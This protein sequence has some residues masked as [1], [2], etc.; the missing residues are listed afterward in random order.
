MSV[1][2]STMSTI[3]GARGWAAAD[4]R[5]VIQSVTAAVA[6]E[7][8][9]RRDANYLMAQSDHMLLDIGISRAELMHA[10]RPVLLNLC[11]SPRCRLQTVILPGPAKPMN[12]SFS[13]RFTIPSRAGLG[14]PNGPV[15]SACS[16]AGPA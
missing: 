2:M 15:V 16:N 12:S 14:C 7:I 6:R 10:A 11:A 5:A 1:K 3:A 9:L 8:R 4:L 13:D